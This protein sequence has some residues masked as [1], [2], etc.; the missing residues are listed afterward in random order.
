[1]R[2]LAL[3]YRPKTLN[4]VVEQIAI[5]QIL[6]QQLKTNTHQSCYL[7]TGAPGVGKTSIARIFA[8][9]LNEGNGTPI[10]IDAASNNGVDDVREIISNVAFK[11]LDSKYKVYILDEVHQFSL[12]AWNA[13]LKLIEEPPAH[14]VFI[15]CTTQPEKVPETIISRVQRF[16][17]RRITY[18]SIIDRL[19][20]I[21]DSEEDV[22]ATDDALAMIA[23]LA[24]GGLRDAITLLDKC[25]SYSDVLDIDAVS[26]ALGTVNYKTMFDLLE[27]IYNKQIKEALIVIDDIYRSGVDL[28]QFVKRFCYFLID[29][30]KYVLTRDFEYIQIPQI[31]EDRLAEIA[32][33][34]DFV[35][36]M[37]LDVQDLS[38]AIK[39]ET[40]SK[41]LIEAKLIEWCY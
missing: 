20:Y 25:L 41:Y 3:K 36:V 26:T 18:N 27:F 5:V 10:E 32:V 6:Q 38:A 17:F 1:M 14:A 19:R 2:A 13:M 30:C 15:L 34:Y 37:M 33:D 24:E 28:K 35:L 23:R 9:E 12:G 39:W 29:S 21:I 7:F 8:N 11:A 16:D 31:Y 4:D 22:S 40:N